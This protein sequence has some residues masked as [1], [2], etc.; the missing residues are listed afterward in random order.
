MTSSDRLDSV[1]HAIA[2]RAPAEEAFHRFVADLAM[3]WPVEYTWSRDVL[4]TIE[5]EPR[6]GGRCFERGPHGFMCDW[7]RVLEYDAPRRLR[8]LW[9]IGPTRVPVPDPE[10]A[11]EVD[12][13]FERE[14]EAST[15]VRLEHRH[16][17]RHG[18]EGD[19]YRD[20][21]ASQ[22]GWPYILDNFAASFSS[23]RPE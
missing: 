9:Q 4:E 7:G 5:I 6:Q 16:F 22:Q 23:R 14:G 15:R 11:S 21:M 2:I 13:R 3:W 10:R 19:S 17:E 12:V 20:A 8:F 18:D 1:I